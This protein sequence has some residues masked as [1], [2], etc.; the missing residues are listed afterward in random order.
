MWLLVVALF[1]LIV[2][3]G[4]F[5]Y[6]LVHDFHGIGTVLQDRLA[7]SFIL[8]AL[9]TLGVLTVHFARQPAARVAWPWFVLFSLAGGL[10]FGVPFYAWLNRTGAVATTPRA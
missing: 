8:D 7:L 3:N 10:C 2:P 1:G 6:W 9:I 5:V 4:L